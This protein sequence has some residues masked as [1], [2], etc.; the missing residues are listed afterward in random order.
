MA[1]A[2]RSGHVDHLRSICAGGAAALLVAVLLSACRSATPSYAS[3]PADDALAHP[4][5][6][7]REVLVRRGT[8]RAVLQGPLS[9]TI[10]IYCADSAT[11]SNW[12]EFDGNGGVLGEGHGGDHAPRAC[13]ICRQHPPRRQASATPAARGAKLHCGQVADCIDTCSSRCPGG[14][15]RIG[16]LIGCRDGCRAKGCTSAQRP[17]DALTGCIQASCL[18]ACIGGPSPGCKRCVVAKC[19]AENAACHRHRCRR[20]VQQSCDAAASD[21]RRRTMMSLLRLSPAEDFS[22]PADTDLA[23]C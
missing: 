14:L 22:Y 17:F 8:P 13:Q 21:P 11:S 2:V 5:G 1:A 23:T 19:S 15:R 12:V 20:S 6:E 3:L 16:C 10:W 4:T 9:T 7:Q 18:G